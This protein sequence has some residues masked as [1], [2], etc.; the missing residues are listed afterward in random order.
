MACNLLRG[1]GPVE[2]VVRSRR[3]LLDALRQ[4]LT[5]ASQ[6]LG[7]LDRCEA[8]IKPQIVHNGTGQQFQIM[9]S[10]TKRDTGHTTRL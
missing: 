9:V 1:N 2:V 5:G 3:G 10:I 7:S 4:A 6:Q 8:T